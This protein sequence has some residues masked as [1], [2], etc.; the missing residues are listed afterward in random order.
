MTCTDATAPR[1]SYLSPQESLVDDASEL[2]TGE[3]V[4]APELSGVRMKH[5]HLISTRIDEPD[6][7]TLTAIIETVDA[8]AFGRHVLRRCVPE[9]AKVCLIAVTRNFEV[10]RVRIV[11]LTHG[12]VREV[13]LF[14]PPRGDPAAVVDQYRSVTSNDIVGALTHRTAPLAPR[15]AKI[16]N[17]PPAGASGSGMGRHPATNVPG[18]AEHT[19]AALP[20]GR[21]DGDGM[22]Q[23][24]NLTGDYRESDGSADGNRAI[25]RPSCT[26][27]RLLS[28]KSRI[29]WCG[30][31]S[32]MNSVTHCH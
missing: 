13:S 2:V 23:T 1:P 15:L 21:D 31:Y 11:L 32:G 18:E 8:R 20:E 27:T 9:C 12:A 6:R 4:G 17:T 7:L 16:K 10:C 26:N 24:A 19:S 29:P 30:I 5:H 22:A 25:Q 28:V 3:S 14:C